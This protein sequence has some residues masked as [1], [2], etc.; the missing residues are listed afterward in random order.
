MDLYRQSA[1]KIWGFYEFYA[2]TAYVSRAGVEL[3]GLAEPNPYDRKDDDYVAK[4]FYRRGESALE[5]QA[6]TALLCN[7]FASNFPN[8]FGPIFCSAYDNHYIWSLV[9]VSLVHDVGEVVIGDIP[10]DGSVEHDMKDESELKI[11]RGKVLAGFSESDANILIKRFQDFQNRRGSFGKAVYALD[12]LEAILNLIHLEKKGLIGDSEMK[13]NRTA[14]D[15]LCAKITG[16]TSATDCWTA[17]LKAQLDEYSEVIR[18]P[19]YAVLGVAIRS[20]RG[21]MFNWWHKDLSELALKY[22]KPSS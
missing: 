20:A 18:N 19:V 9:S 21:E 22:N 15:C 17:R 6:K 1:E 5:H 11:F 14:S 10:D 2:N 3:Y 4:S 16:T 12:K 13:D 8:F 7:L